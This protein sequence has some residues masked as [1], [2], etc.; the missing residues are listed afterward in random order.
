MPVDQLSRD[1][2]GCAE[3]AF[4][5][6]PSDS[7]DLSRIVRQIYVGTGGDV[8]IITKAGTTVTHSNMQT[9]SYLSG[10]RVARV[11]STGTTASSLIGYV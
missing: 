5:I 10:L 1:A 9:G 6:T 4:A 8:K 11:L 3:D 7:A 2:V